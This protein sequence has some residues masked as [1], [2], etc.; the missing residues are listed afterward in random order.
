MDDAKLGAAVRAVRI[1]KRLTQADLAQKASVRPSDV[2]H[3]ER[4]LLDTLSVSTVRRIAAALGM[5]LEITPRWRGVDLV[6]LVN[7][8]HAALQGA[9]LRHFGRSPGWTTMSEVS[10]SI[11]GERGAIDVLAWHAA[12]RTA[13]IIELK[14]LLVDPGELVRKMGE[15]ARLV[16][17]IA[18]DQGWRP[19]VVAQ[20]VILTDTRTNRRHVAA[21][22]ELLGTL[23]VM[24]GRS[25]RSWLR[26]PV[27]A[28]SALSFWSEAGAIIPQRVRVGRR[29]I[30]RSIDTPPPRSTHDPPE[31]R[32]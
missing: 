8:A 5:W 11:Y 19:E 13:L 7:S 15:R 3:L 16:H 9:V 23:T 24:N 25:M 28:I 21:H 29:R 14:T 10:Y 31:L 30:A 20:W 17:R 6:R 18:A 4:G 26:S 12:T 22:R 2:S 1:R 27:G 32:V